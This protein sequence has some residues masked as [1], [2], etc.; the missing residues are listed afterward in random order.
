MGT[1]VKE[2]ANQADN[3]AYKLTSDEASADA[4]LTTSNTYLNYALDGF[5]TNEDGVVED[6]IEGTINCSIYYVSQMAYMEVG[7]HY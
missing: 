4:R 7:V 1:Y 6:L 3:V 5:D 2:A